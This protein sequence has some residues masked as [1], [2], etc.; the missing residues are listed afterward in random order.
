M[1]RYILLLLLLATSHMMAQELSME[2]QLR[3]LAYKVDSLSHVVASFQKEEEQE[4]QNRSDESDLLLYM[5]QEKQM[6][7][8]RPKIYGSLRAKFEW[9]TSGGDV[10]F[11]LRNARLGVMG[12]FNPY[13]SYKLEV[14]FSDAGK[15]NPTN[16][17]IRYNT[18]NRFFFTIGHIKSPWGLDITR[19]INQYHFVNRAFL[20]KQI[21]A[22]SRDLGMTVSYLGKSKATPFEATIGVFNSTGYSVPTFQKGLSAVAQVSVKPHKNW[23]ISAGFNTRDADAQYY[24]QTASSTFDTV[25][26]ARSF[27]YDL[28]T[29]VT[30][31]GLHLEA[32]VVYKSYSAN[33]APATWAYQ[34]FASYDFDLKKC[35]ALSRISPRL[36]YDYMGENHTWRY[37]LDKSNLASHRVD[38]ERSRVTAGL[39]FSLDKPFLADIQINYEKYFTPNSNR[40]A[41]EGMEDK[42]SIQCVVRF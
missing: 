38:S 35:G 22:Y 14:D 23:Y 13:I 21:V 25:Q 12:N 30:W 19:S 17:Y 26:V 2:Q 5:A 3:E 15:I 7:D 9:N 36:R 40:V 11:Q 42:L 28:A 39:T 37:S 10:R 27:L 20:S 34:L 18:P 4:K 16:M 31:R 32:E 41:A 29:Y 8:W 6:N 1:P 33:Y 24:N